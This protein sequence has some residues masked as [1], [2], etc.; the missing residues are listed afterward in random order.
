MVNTG[1]RPVYV[2]FIIHNKCHISRVLFVVPL[3]H[4]KTKLNFFHL[5]HF[6]VVLKRVAVG[7][8]RNKLHDNIFIYSHSLYIML[9]MKRVSFYYNYLQILGICSIHHVA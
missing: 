9:T 2:L 7:A 1:L 8:A 5:V 3:L 4:L 6:A